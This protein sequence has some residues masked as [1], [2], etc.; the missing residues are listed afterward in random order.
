VRSRLFVVPLAVLL[1]LGATSC[2][3][4]SRDDAREEF[5]TQLVDE[6]GLPP[7]LADCVADRFMASRTDQEL[8]EFFARL[9]LTVAEQDEFAA[10]A[11][12]CGVV[13][14]PTAPTT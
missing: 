2:R 1:A 10:I 7:E 8:K 6:G 4:S 12:E 5:I 11:A 9:E 3:G 14:E 13:A